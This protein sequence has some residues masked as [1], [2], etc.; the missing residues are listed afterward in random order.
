MPPVLSVSLYPAGEWGI[1][2]ST[3]IHESSDGPLAD[4]DG[5]CKM[6][7]LPCPLWPQQYFLLLSRILIFN[8]ISLLKNHLTPM[9]LVF[10]STLSTLYLLYLLVD[11]K[12]Y[13]N[14]WENKYNLSISINV[15][16]FESSVTGFYV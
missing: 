3:E 1:L 12:N 5:P 4:T 16:L 14:L 13:I 9:L 10:W 8:K 15:F 7:S 6:S 11:F 2:V